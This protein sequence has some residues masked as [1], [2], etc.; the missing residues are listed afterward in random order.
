V[1]QE[2]NKVLLE[3]DSIEVQAQDISVQI[4]QDA[5]VQTEVLDILGQKDR[6][7]HLENEEVI[8]IL[9]FYTF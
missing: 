5:L 6:L 4:V 9:I 3:E 1:L 7:E 2:Q 8:N